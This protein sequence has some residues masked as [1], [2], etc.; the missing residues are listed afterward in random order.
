MVQGMLTGGTTSFSRS[1]R[2]AA[3]VA[4]AA[5]W[6]A[7]QVFAAPPSADQTA[8]R[9]EF[10][11]WL[12]EKKGGVFRVWECEAGVLC[13]TLVGMDYE[14]AEPAKDVWG[15]SECNLPLLTGFRKKSSDQK[16]WEGS[17]LDPDSGKVY[18]AQI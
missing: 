7:E 2:R 6:P 14:E 5:F 18:H 16:R 9:P 3:L 13:G 12:S 15:R 11:L 8:A 10:G 17:I 4:F 1:F